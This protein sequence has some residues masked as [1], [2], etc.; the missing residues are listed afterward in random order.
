M[1]PPANNHI[2]LTGATGYIGGTVL[3]SLVK[4]QEPSLKS[5]TFDTPVRR[6]DQ[7]EKLRDVYGSR[8][9]PILWNGPDDAAWM[10]DTAA[11]YDLILNAGLAF[12]ANGGKPFVDGL[13]RRL[14]NGSGKPE[15]APWILHVGGCTNVSD[16]PLTQEAFPDRVWDD[17]D[18][19]AVYEFIKSEDAK[20][21]YVQRTNEVNTLAAAE[22][23]GVQALSLNTP[24]IFGEGK[25]QFNTVRHFN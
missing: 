15:E 22:E 12:H 5:I 13:A 14:K 1:P 24:L 9:N 7:A 18:P 25:G 3:D 8:V 10:A 2:L 20:D 4:S 11:N 21:P 6:Q 16:R 23:T 17:A 19:G